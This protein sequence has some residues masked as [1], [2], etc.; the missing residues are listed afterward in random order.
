[1]VVEAEGEG[2]GSLTSLSRFRRLEGGGGIGKEKGQ[3]G[4][5]RR[6]RLVG[7]GGGR[8]CACS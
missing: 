7:K 2:G 5:S 4:I 8:E 1:M 6:G 3:N